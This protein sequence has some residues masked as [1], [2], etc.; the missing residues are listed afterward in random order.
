M[1]TNNLEYQLNTVRIRL[2]PDIPLFS[3]RPVN[4]PDDAADLMG[5]RQR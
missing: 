2:V 5:R 4:S 1:A 3:D